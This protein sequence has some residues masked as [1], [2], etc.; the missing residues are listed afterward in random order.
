VKDVQSFVQWLQLMDSLYEKHSVACV[1]LIKY[2]TE[3]VSL[4]LKIKII[5]TNDKRAP[6]RNLAIRSQRNIC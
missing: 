1:W 2:L 6:D 3:N 5:E 4:I